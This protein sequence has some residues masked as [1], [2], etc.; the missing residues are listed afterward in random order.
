[1]MAR[2]VLAMMAVGVVMGIMMLMDTMM[3]DADD[4]GCNRDDE[5][6]KVDSGADEGKCAS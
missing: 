3:F 4:D 2:M 1:M 6:K 5:V